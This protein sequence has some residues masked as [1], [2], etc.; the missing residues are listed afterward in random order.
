MA[1]AHTFILRPIGTSLL[2]VGLAIFGWIAFFLL[3]VA[4]LPQVEYPTISIKT[5]LPGA[6]PVTVANS[7]TAPLE[8]QLGHIS[9]LRQMTSSSFNSMSRIVLQFDLSR[10]INGAAR[11][12]QAAIDGAKNDIPADIPLNPTYTKSNPSDAPIM[13]LALTSDTMTR[14]QLY[15][16]ASSLLQEKLM[17]VQGVGDVTIGGGALPAV[18]VELNPNR[19]SQ[20][21]ISLENIRK[22]LME[23]NVHQALGSVSLG[24]QAYSI[25]GNDALD[26][27]KDYQPLVIKTKDGIV[28]LSDFGNILD[29]VEDV[30][31]FGLMNGKPAVLLVIFKQPGA[32][33]IETLENVKGQLAILNQ[34][35]PKSAKVDIVG[36]RTTTIRAALYDIEVT[37]LISIFLVVAITLVFFRDWRAAVVPAIAVPLSLLGTFVVIYWLG[38]SLNILSLMALAISTGFVVDDAIVVTE[39]IMRHIEDGMSAL[40]AAIQGTREVSF[41]VFSISISLIAVFIPLLL[42]GGI[43]GR[44][45]KEFAV[46]MAI[47]I[48]ISMALSLTLTP[49]MSRLLLRKTHSREKKSFE[50]GEGRIYQWYRRSLRFTLRHPTGI[51]VISALVVVCNVAL[52]IAI[53]KGFF[54]QEDIGKISGVMVGSQDASFPEM[55]RN[56]QALQ[57]KLRE[58][59]DVD[60]VVAFVGSNQTSNLG[61]IYIYL[62]KLGQREKSADE[63][64]ARLLTLA[65]EV[66]AAR[67][68]LQADQNL[69]IGGRKSAAQFQFTLK[70]QTLGDLTAWGPRV[71]KALQGIPSIMQVNTNRLNRG[72]QRY[73]DVDRPMASRLGVNTAVLDQTLY[74]AFGQ[75]RISTLYY[76][77]NQYRLVMEVLPEYRERLDILNQIWVPVGDDTNTVGQAVSSSPLQARAQNANLDG[78]MVPLSA[79]ASFRDRQSY[80]IISHTD[81]FPSETISFNLANGAS[82]STATQAIA[83]EVEKLHLPAGVTG[84]FGGSAQ[85][86]QDSMSDEPILVGVS[87]LAVYIVLGI[88]Y[89]SLVHPLT[90]LSTLPSAGVGALAALMIFHY[91]L[92]VIALIGVILL[93]GIVKKNAIMLIDFALEQERLHGLLPEEAIFNACMIRLRPILMTTLA[94]LLGALPLVFGSGYGSEFRKPLGIS[95]IGG[96]II[97][98]LLTLYSTPV[99]YLVLDRMKNRALV[100]SKAPHGIR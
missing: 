51:L 61:T 71:L 6:D 97:S 36:D 8:R 20:Y 72:L 41:T 76:P 98:Q 12:V 22:F 50:D 75:R 3:P 93:I 27:A 96:L 64:V 68:Y 46:S 13:L 15:D 85:A 89:E 62:N 18:R 17:Q 48:L 7:L 35:I 77:S 84:E 42:M 82:L 45:L 34:S 33:V 2:A 44:L 31:N 40:D 19:L 53:P 94:A 4:P 58:D 10:D 81:Q 66:P 56:L 23:S 30:N 16:I 99:V 32:N 1:L 100:R 47:A 63:V 92:S 83:E 86:F 79:F 5:Q 28:H 52:F 59:P 91:D 29:S 65:A 60:S 25:A 24:D 80:L 67:V 69:V 70:A 49:M 74:D 88:L 14:S 43:V 38:F 95:I 39:N 11:D 54:P 26:H 55:Q 90:I 57:D 9:G 37:L 87:I 21:K 78:P 73:V